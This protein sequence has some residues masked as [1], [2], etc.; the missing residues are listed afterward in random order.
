MSKKRSYLMVNYLYPK[1]KWNL[2]RVH[3]HDNNELD[4][5]DDLGQF[6]VK[7]GKVVWNFK[8]CCLTLDEVEKIYF[9]IMR[10]GNR[11][12]IEKME[13]EQRRLDIE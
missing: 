9:E 6:C 8:G 4:W 5:V 2:R 1:K 12:V 10:L 11:M 3:P 13:E 7:E